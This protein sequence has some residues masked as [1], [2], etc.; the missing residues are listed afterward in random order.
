MSL[1]RKASPCSATPFPENRFFHLSRVQLSS[2][3]KELEFMHV[4]NQL[5]GALAI[6]WIVISYSTQGAPAGDKPKK[7]KPDVSE[8]FFSSGRIPHV[9]IT[10]DQTNLAALKKDNRKYVKCTVRDGETVH[11]DVGIHLK[12]AAG[13]FRGLED[14]PALTLNFT[15][16]KSGQRFYGL[17]KVHLNNSV[18]DPSYMT[19]LLCG[20]LFRAADVPAARTTH[21]RVEFNGR[22]LG[23]FV[24]KE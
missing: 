22:D 3:A 9:K 21:A 16:F 2:V 10:L 15:K 5:F 20:E 13:S 17:D 23:L 11:S 12:G 7:Q 18:Q 4:R 24:L 1:S 6:V 14:K 8:E 19:E